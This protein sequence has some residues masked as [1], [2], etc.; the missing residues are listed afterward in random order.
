MPKGRVRLDKLLVDRG[1]AP[2]RQRAQALV[3][4]GA[5]L[6]NEI[7]RDKPGA[8]IDADAPVRLKSNP[9]PYVSR[10]GLKLE[11][12]LDAFE[13]EPAGLVAADLGAS[14]GGFT[15]CLLQ[16]GAAKVYAV[17]VGY[18]QLA[19]SLR[20]DPRVVVMERTNARHLESLPEPIEMLVGDLS[21]ISITKVLPAIRRL[22]NEHTQI[23]LLI[24]PQFEVGKTALAKG[25]VVRDATARQEA[26]QSIVNAVT[27]LEATVHG[28]IDS[29]IAGA[30]KGNIEALI[31]FTMGA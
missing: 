13:L 14:T 19:W 23:V 17:D 30:K 10:G 20:T 24:K 7:P 1:L 9:I 21:F 6:V 25:G 4:S 22:T 12:A 3:R 16:R 8:Q 2:T 26:I 29:P 18:G 27:D 28:V 15:D 11:A 31:H 5:V